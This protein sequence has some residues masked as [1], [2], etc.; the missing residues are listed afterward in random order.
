VD[1]AADDSLAATQMTWRNDIQVEFTKFRLQHEVSVK[2][3][4]FIYTGVIAD[5]CYTDSSLLLQATLQAR[6]AEID[7]LKQQIARL[8]KQQ[9]PSQAIKSDR[10]RQKLRRRGRKNKA[11]P[12][13]TDDEWDVRV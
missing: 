8:E 3:I 6:S 7:E 1:D 13:D 4:F 10:S 2:P 11:M 12:S 9:G 5:Y